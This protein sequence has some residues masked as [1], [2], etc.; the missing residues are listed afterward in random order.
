MTLLAAG[1]LVLALWLVPSPA[2]DG[3]AR[4]D[5]RPSPAPEPGARLVGVDDT[6]ADEPWVEVPPGPHAAPEPDERAEGRGSPASEVPPRTEREHYERFLALSRAGELEAAAAELGAAAPAAQRVALLR[7]L[8]ETG[9]P[10]AEEHLVAALRAPLAPSGLAGEPVPSFAVRYLGERA[11]RDAVARAALRRAVF[12]PGPPIDANLRRRGAAHL[13]ASE[14]GPEL[15][16]L[17]DRLAFE[18]DEL[19]VRGALVA[20]ARNPDRYL[21]Q[22]ILDEHAPPP[23]RSPTGRAAR[24]VPP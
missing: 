15:R 1:A 11:P 2:G 22:A 10:A 17:G 3:A 13:A 5:A 23:R 6:S 12:G 21:A 8:V 4:A 24:D 19:L 14:A 7:A 20:L 9:S 16:A 18:T